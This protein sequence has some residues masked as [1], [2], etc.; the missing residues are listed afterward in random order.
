[1]IRRLTNRTADISIDDMI[2]RINDI[3]DYINQKEFEGEF[4]PDTRRND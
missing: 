1:M 3:I 4:K 2:N